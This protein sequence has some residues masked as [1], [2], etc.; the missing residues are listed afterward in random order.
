MPVHVSASIGTVDASGDIEPILSL[1]LKPAH[2]GF[3][4][5]KHNNPHNTRTQYESIQRNHL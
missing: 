4:S 5:D 3:I 2:S 1:F